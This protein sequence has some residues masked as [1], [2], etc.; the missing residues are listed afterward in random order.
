MLVHGAGSGPW[1]FDGWDPEGR[2]LDVSAVDLQRG[3]DVSTASMADYAR[4]LVKYC[5]GLPRPLA[6]CGWSMGG[7]VAMMAARDVRPA[8]LVLLEPSPPAEVQGANAVE[9]VTGT[10]DPERVY[11]TFPQGTPARAESQRARADRKRGISVP[12]LP[13]RTLVVYGDEF[14]HDRGR[15][16]ARLYGAD[17]AHFPGVDHWGL[18][19]DPR[20]RERVFEYVLHRPG[21]AGAAASS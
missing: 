21:R 12:R 14:R 8:S 6:V 2:A 16:V 3:V 17:E 18:V 10:F 19:L 5:R 9:D 13:A 1:V 20:V 11:G 15:D 7:L 4:E